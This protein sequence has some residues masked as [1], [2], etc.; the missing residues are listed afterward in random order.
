VLIFGY[1][2]T[3][4]RPKKPRVVVRAFSNPGM[5]FFK[6]F[7]EGGEQCTGMPNW[8]SFTHFWVNDP[9]PLL[10]TP[11]CDETS[12]SR[13]RANV[14][15]FTSRAL[16]L[17]SEQLLTLHERI[18]LCLHKDPSTY[19]HTKASPAILFQNFSSGNESLE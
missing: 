14:A 6:S 13:T 17:T 19:Y 11:L 4:S 9:L 8:V 5:W 2:E 12:V 18:F 10:T 3:I 1:C 15:L 16:R 7:H